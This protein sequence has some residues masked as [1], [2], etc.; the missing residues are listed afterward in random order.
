MKDAYSEFKRDKTKMINIKEKEQQ[1]FLS[2][3]LNRG[4]CYTNS[5]SCL[6][7]RCKENKQHWHL[8][9]QMCADVTQI[10]G[11]FQWQW[12]EMIMIKLRDECWIISFSFV[13]PQNQRSALLHVHQCVDSATTRNRIIASGCPS[14]TLLIRKRNWERKTKS[15]QYHQSVISAFTLLYLTEW[16]KLRSSYLLMT[17]PCLHLWWCNDESKSLSDP[18]MSAITSNQME[19]RKSSV[20][21][22]GTILNCS[23]DR[24]YRRGGWARWKAQNDRK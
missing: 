14:S 6:W 23:R 22:S 13:L 2:V 10:C 21:Q 12:P 4:E 3:I 16:E 1:S 18:F 5:T 9:Q 11:C 8:Q 19:K 7:R 24:N 15:S 20:I 17:D